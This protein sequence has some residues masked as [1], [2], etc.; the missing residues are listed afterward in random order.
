MPATPAGWIPPTRLSG[1]SS[2]APRS[3]SSLPDG[4][5]TCPTAGC[6]TISVGSALRCSPSSARLGSRRPTG[7][8]STPSAPPWSAPQDLGWQPHLGRGGVLASPDQRAAHRHP[9]AP[10]PS[11]AAGRA[12][13]RTQT[14]PGRS[15]HPHPGPRP[16]S[17]AFAR[18]PI[19]YRAIVTEP[20]NGAA[21]MA[22]LPTP[23][24]TAIGGGSGI[25]ACALSRH[26]RL[27]SPAGASRRTHRRPL[28]GRHNPYP[29]THY[30]ELNGSPEHSYALYHRGAA[31][32][33]GRLRTRDRRSCCSD[34]LLQVS[35]D[36]RTSSLSGCVQ[37]ARTF[38]VERTVFRL[39]S[40]GMVGLGGVEPPTSS[41]SAKCKE[42]LCRRLF[43]QVARDRRCRS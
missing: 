28:P 1:P 40:S 43:P 6:W 20:V 25:P 38:K 36:S 21:T 26:R 7:T 41:L 14:G 11:R 2:S 8:P 42:P 35:K 15:G 19:R 32:H 37:A 10:R 4:P 23:A 34:A 24:H 3:T 16:V 17:A 29:L 39:V 31:K 12:A 27:I 30:F 9:A 18:A 5:P 33:T 13:A 22:V